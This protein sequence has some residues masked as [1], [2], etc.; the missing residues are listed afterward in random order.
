MKN[1][2]GAVTS[3]VAVL[4]V[5]SN[6]VPSLHWVDQLK[7]PAENGCYPFKL[8]ALR[9]NSDATNFTA[10]KVERVVSGSL[11]INNVPFRSDNC[12]IGPSDKAIWSPPH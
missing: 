1:N 10:F 4:T 8:Q 9:D 7:I 5:I 6:G 2:F 3:A 12:I 11:S